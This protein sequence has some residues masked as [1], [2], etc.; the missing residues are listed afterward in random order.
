MVTDRQVRLLM[1]LDAKGERPETSAAKAGMDEKTAR[2]YRRV[3][4]LPSQVR[5]PHLWRTRE[6]PFT[7]V[8]EEAR[9]NLELLPGVEAKTLFEHLRREY[10]GRFSDGQLRTFQRRVKEWHALEGPAQEVFFPQVHHPGD[11]SESDFTCMNS[12]GVTINHQHFRHLIYHFVLTYSN[13]ETGTI[14]F[15]E[16]FES[17]GQGLQGALWKLGGVPKRHRSD[18]LSAAVHNACQREEFTVRYQALLKHYRTD[19][20]KIRAGEAHENGDVEQRH[21][22]LKRALDQ[23]LLLRG[24][25]DFQSR[26]DYAAFLERFFD[27]LNA[28]RRV[29]LEEE[30]AVLGR[31]PERRFDDH[32]WIRARVGL[33]STV[34]VANNSYSVSSRLRGEIVDVKIGAEE[35]EVWYGRRRVERIPRL[36]GQDGHRIDYRH[37]IDWLVRKPG[38]FENYRYKEDLFPTT[39]FRMAYDSLRRVNP[40]QANREYVGLLYLAAKESETAV[41]EALRRLMEEETP[42]GLEAVRRIVQSGEK[43]VPYREVHVQTVDLSHYDD[44]LGAKEAGDGLQG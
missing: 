13:W 38:A 3:G 21:Y 20:E 42:V 7:E 17:L 19:G 22:R 2:K 31:L 11:L 29:R 33:A 37:I 9:G 10:P 40:L 30:L 27:E 14:C 18:R 1:E 6:D 24:S 44:L 26:E 23:A 28:G 16:S 25:R 35:L 36:R 43:L 15:S 39:R 41:N 5:V 32:R 8:W 4:K 34:R 12:L